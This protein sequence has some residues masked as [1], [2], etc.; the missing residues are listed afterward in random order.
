MASKQALEP[1]SSD[2]ETDYI[3]RGKS[4]WITVHNLS[5][6]IHRTDEGVVVDVY[7]HGGPAGDSPNES[8]DTLATTYAFFAEGPLK[9]LCPTC[10]EP[11]DAHAENCKE[12]LPTAPR[13]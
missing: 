11:T 13:G 7:G 2:D 10:K 9:K 1:Q 8:E 12:G 3:L 4:T 5:V 6:Y